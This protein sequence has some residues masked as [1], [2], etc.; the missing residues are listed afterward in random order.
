MT[1]K[2]GHVES[3]GSNEHKRHLFEGFNSPY[4]MFFIKNLFFNI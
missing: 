3:G 4:Q 1:K 2:I